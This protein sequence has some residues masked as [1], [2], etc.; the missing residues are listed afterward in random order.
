MDLLQ[1]R[2]F[3]YF[4]AQIAGE[5]IL[6]IPWSAIPRA[7]GTVRRRFCATRHDLFFYASVVEVFS[8]RTHFGG[9]CAA[10]RG[11]SWSPKCG[12]VCIAF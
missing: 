2:I 10:K 6:D 12:K 5:L 7:L 1:K 11:L 4:G 3:G 8:E 9:G